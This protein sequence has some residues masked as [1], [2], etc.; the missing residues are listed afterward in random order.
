[1]LKTVEPKKDSEIIL[2]GN[3][4]SLKWT[5]SKISG[6]EISVPADIKKQ[7]NEEEQLAFTFKIQN[8]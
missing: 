6:L 7:L 1:V 2:L 8:L 4:K 5:Y 3:K